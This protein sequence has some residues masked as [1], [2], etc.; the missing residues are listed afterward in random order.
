MASMSFDALLSALV[1]VD[2]FRQSMQDD[3]STLPQ[4]LFLSIAKG[5]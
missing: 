1:S 3:V 2:E 4:I 5:Q